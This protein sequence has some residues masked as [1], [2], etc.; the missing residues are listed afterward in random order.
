MPNSRAQFTASSGA[1]W[2]DLPR[3]ASICICGVLLLIGTIFAQQTDW[4]LTSNNTDIQYRDQV[5]DRAQAC[6]LEYRDQKQGPGY[7]TF[8]VAVDYNS[9][10]LSTDGKP[11][12]KTDTEHIVTAPTHTGSARIPNCSGV[13]EARVSFVQRH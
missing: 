5:L 11:T 12:K 4:I 2:F 1:R 9:T 3:R 13:I 10:D 6:Y 8:D 7:T